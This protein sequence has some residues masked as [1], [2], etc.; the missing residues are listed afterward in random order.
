MGINSSGEHDAQRAQSAATDKEEGRRAG[1]AGRIRYDRS[2]FSRAERSNLFASA[3]LPLPDQRPGEQRERATTMDMFDGQTNW[4]ALDDSDFGGSPSRRQS[5]GHSVSPNQNR[6]GLGSVGGHMQ[7]QSRGTKGTFAS[8]ERDRLLHD[9]ET[10]FNPKRQPASPALPVRSPSAAPAHRGGLAATAPAFSPSANFGGGG[11]ISASNSHETLGMGSTS[12][13]GSAEPP[14]FPRQMRLVVAEAMRD[15]TFQP[16]SDPAPVRH[17]QHQQQLLQQEQQRRKEE[18]SLRSAAATSAS[19]S[20]SALLMTAPAAKSKGASAAKRAGKSAVGSAAMAREWGSTGG[21]GGNHPSVDALQEQHLGPARRAASAGN[22]ALPLRVRPRSEG[23]SRA[24]T[25]RSAAHTPATAQQSLSAAG[26][27]RTRNPAPGNPPPGVSSENFSLKLRTEYAEARLRN[28]VRR[29]LDPDQEDI[30][31]PQLPDDL[32][33]PE[34]GLYE[35]EL[36]EMAGRD[37]TAAEEAAEAAKRRPHNPK[38]PIY[39]TVFPPPDITDPDVLLWTKKGYYS[40]TGVWVPAEVTNV[41]TR[42]EE[43][44]RTL[45]ATASTLKTTTKSPAGVATPTPVGP[46]K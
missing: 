16:H 21:G 25:S 38:A 46:W 42:L 18:S 34:A 28:P 6:N 30:P 1:T 23:P 41:K 43:K 22:L 12:R 33:A 31:A 14:E 40:R 36:D 8:P 35:V 45:S 15:L 37:P 19:A 32:T 44:Q 17:Q 4:G 27:F 9:G 24:G 39:A 3:G 5:R 26:W 13:A 29:L 11:A 2:F 7:V 10:T 20:A